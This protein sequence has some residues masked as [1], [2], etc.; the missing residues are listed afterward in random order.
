M[1]SGVIKRGQQLYI[2][3]PR[4]D[5]RDDVKMVVCEED[6]PEHCNLFTVGDLFILM[7]RE[8]VLV[9]QVPAGNIVGIAGVD[10]FII[11]SAT[12]S[13]TLACPAF[14]PMVFAAAPIVRVAIEPLNAADMPALVNGMKLLNQA[15]PSVE[16]YVQETGE[17]VLATA[18][19]VHLKKCIDDLHK[20][21]AKIELRVSDPI[22][23]FR[24]TV[25]PPPKM[26]MVNEVISSDNEIKVSIPLSDIKDQNSLSTQRTQLLK[27]DALPLPEEITKLLETNDDILKSLA[28]LI[29]SKRE[30]KLNQKI[31]DKL[32]ELK[33]SLKSAFDSHCHDNATWV[34]AVDRIWSFGPKHV[35]PNILLNCIPSYHRLSVWSAL[36]SIKCPPLREND[37]SI[38][39]G[40]QLA[41]LSGPLCE[42]PMWGVCFV[43]R[44]WNMEEDLKCQ[45]NVKD[46]KFTI[47]RECSNFTTV[48][49]PKKKITSGQL[50][51][52]MKDTCRRAFLKRP[53]RLMSAMYTC[54]I[55]ATAD[56]LGRL[57]SVLGRCDGRVLSEEMKEGSTVFIIEALIPVAE[58]FG[59][60]E[61]LRKKT[62]GLA[63][64]QLV[65][66]HWEVC[67]YMYLLC[68]C[69]CVCVFVC[70]WGVCMCVCV[71]VC[72][73]VCG[74][75]C[76][77]VC[78]VCMC[79]CGVCIVL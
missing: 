9:D 61:E 78:V 37:N 6:L 64:P 75:V 57:H 44:E 67:R 2:L 58:S 45:S 22:I 8:V 29:S 59:L 35:G 15:D 19:E 74:G 25:I 10:D 77:C 5:P 21:Y 13:S 38:V 79:V 47:D 71:C 24:E 63:S 69:V 62:S 4:Y 17:H 30:V 49:V 42:E 40:F 31:I 26:D 73:C 70:V 72:V 53:A 27:I 68:V 52:T 55:L 76:V 32:L 50:I 56:V 18:G 51:S 7:G 39:S 33:S 20:L 1:Y 36:D 28:L 43:I 46:M 60:A 11:K 3:Q 54:R 14:R 48:S 41:T 65:F 66:S 16:V 23:P 12:I 34:D